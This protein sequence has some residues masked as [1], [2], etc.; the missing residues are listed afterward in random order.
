M[1]NRE[2]QNPGTS[3]NVPKIKNDDEI[4]GGSHAVPAFR[5]LGNDMVGA[6]PTEPGLLLPGRLLAPGVPSTRAMEV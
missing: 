6:R 4:N 3:L 1:F 2:E 5:L